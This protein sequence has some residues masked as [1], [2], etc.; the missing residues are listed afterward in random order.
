MQAARADVGRRGYACNVR[1]WLEGPVSTDASR[2]KAQA[3]GFPGMISGQNHRILGL[4][5]TGASQVPCFSRSFGNRD[6]APACTCVD[7][8]AIPRDARGINWGCEKC[9]GRWALMSGPDGA[10]AD[11]GGLQQR[12]I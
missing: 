11:L 5:S 4:K 1:L 10:G 7:R 3:E 6:L 12:H 9:H 8:R 2:D